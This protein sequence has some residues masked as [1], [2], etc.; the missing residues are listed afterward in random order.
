MSLKIGEL[1]D[2]VV[3]VPKRAMKHATRQVLLWIFPNPK[4]VLEKWTS[5][6]LSQGKLAHKIA[7]GL[8]WFAVKK[9]VT[10][11]GPVDLYEHTLSDAT[12][13]FR[14]DDEGFLIAIEPNLDSVKEEQ[15]LRFETIEDF[16]TLIKETTGTDPLVFHSEMIESWQKALEDSEEQAA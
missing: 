12:W 2:T 7:F 1:Y 16:A 13:F 15:Q 5:E 8:S 14:V 9:I 10:R 3:D 6:L 11:N 4:K